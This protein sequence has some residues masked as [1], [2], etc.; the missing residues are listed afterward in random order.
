MNQKIIDNFE[1]DTENYF[2][3]HNQTRLK[4]FSFQHIATVALKS[5]DRFVKFQQRT[6]SMFISTC[7][8]GF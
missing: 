6:I 2:Y 3:L 1:N 5:K 4:L 7:I 8:S